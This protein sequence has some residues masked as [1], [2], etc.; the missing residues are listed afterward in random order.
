MTYYFNQYYKCG[1]KKFHN[2]WQAF[3]EQRST[4]HFPEYVVDEQLIKS[5]SN[6]PRPK[7]TSPNAIRGLMVRRLKA[8]RQ[9]Y[10][11]LKILYSGGTDSYTI[12]KLCIDNDIYV[13]ETIT[14]MVS[15]ENNLRTNLEYVAALRI[16]KRYEGTLIGKCR[17]IHPT[18]E[19]HRKFYTDD[20][21]KDEKLCPGANLP[22]RP[23]GLP[24]IAEE[25]MGDDKDT[26]L[27][28]GYEKP[29]I[30]VEDHKPYWVLG[31]AAAGEIM[32]IK[33]LVPFFHDKDNPE[34]LVS[35]TY[36]TMDKM[37]YSKPGMVSYHDADRKTKFELLEAYAYHTTGH[38]FLDMAI[39]GKEPYNVNRKNMRLMK[40]LARVGMDDYMEQHF[41]T[42]ARIKSLYNDL[43]Y[44]IEKR[45]RLVKPIGRYSQKIPILQDKFGG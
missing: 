7:D 41:R 25:A 10:N 17:Q 40:E 26:I 12:L 3:D 4:G 19:E 22:R 13:D 37:D 23:Y 18:L 21:F 28:C 1:D 9:K 20:W 6:H 30:V 38:N 45:G 34:L 11:K 8:L 33:N 32:G 2:I 5:I 43:P 14:H 16:A 24:L 35:L 44:A 39:L 42:H 36:V 27:L 15:I 29:K 31:D